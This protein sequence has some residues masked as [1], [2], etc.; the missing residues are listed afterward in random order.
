MLA[1]SASE[2]K[3]ADVAKSISDSEDK[4]QKIADRADNVVLKLSQAGK[5]YFSN[6]LSLFLDDLAAASAALQSLK[7]S[8]AK[9]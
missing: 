5:T 7:E 8:P 6:L 1:L 3:I 9:L 4:I 2:M